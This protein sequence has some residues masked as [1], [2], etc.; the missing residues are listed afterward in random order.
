VLMA[1]RATMAKPIMTRV[2]AEERILLIEVE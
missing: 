2:E 1:V